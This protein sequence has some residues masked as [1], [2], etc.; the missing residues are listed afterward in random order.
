[1]SAMYTDTQSEFSS[2]DTHHFV[3]ESRTSVDD[4]A[5]RAA[6]L[7]HDF[8]A[9]SA[10]ARLRHLQ[11]EIGQ[12]IVLTTGFGPESQVIVHLLAKH[13]IPIDIVTLDT[14]RLFPETYKLWEDTERRYGLR[15]RAVY[16]RHEA[17][18]TLV[19]KHGVNGF[20]ASKEARLSCCYVRKVEPL[21]RA[22]AGANAWVTGVRGTQSAR[23]AT[24]GF[25]GVDREH[26]VIKVNPLFDWSRDQ[27]FEF[28]RKNGVPINSLHDKGFA[29][30]GCAPCTRATRPGEPERAGRWWW[31]AGDKKE[32]GL[33]LGHERPV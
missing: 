29:S 32:C 22:L 10:P 20:Y 21:S 24:A 27:V 25:V 3:A 2:S 12:G 17:V 19:E 13:D 26:K 1:M 7:D 31:E 14:G 33:H 18:E 15:I 8:G 28:V 30:I 6:Q 4:V 23:R 5:A 11:R 9:L 16:P